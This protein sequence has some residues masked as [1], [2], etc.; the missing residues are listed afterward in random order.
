MFDPFDPWLYEIC[1]PGAVSGM[2]EVS[3]PGCGV[4]LTVAVA[5]PMGRQTYRCTECNS[6][7][8]V[9]WGK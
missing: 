4:V 8:T 3:C 6:E 5:D 7:F 9:N 1:F 2:A